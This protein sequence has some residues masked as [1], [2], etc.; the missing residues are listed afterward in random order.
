VI[1]IIITTTKRGDN[2]G[3]KRTVV[4]CTLIASSP[5]VET[6]AATA[7][8][9][10]LLVMKHSAA[11]LTTAHKIEPHYVTENLKMTYSGRNTLFYTPSTITVIFIIQ[12]IYIII[13]III[14]IQF[15]EYLL[16]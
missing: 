4:S 6:P 8:E 12:L 1:N 9:T 10:I 13:I 2:L 11:T 3:T 14:I 5:A 7:Q 16:T 15:N